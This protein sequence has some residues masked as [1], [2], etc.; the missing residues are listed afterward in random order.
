MASE[1]PTL[2]I[3]PRLRPHIAELEFD[4]ESYAY[5][6]S[7]MGA[8]NEVIADTEIALLGSTKTTNVS[9]GRIALGQYDEL[10]NRISIWPLA[11]A[12]RLKGCLPHVPQE[13]LSQSKTPLSGAHN[14]ILL[15][16][17]GHLVD[18]HRTDPLER[19][20]TNA[21]IFER[22]LDM[23]TKVA[24]GAVSGAIIGSEAAAFADVRSYV[25]SIVGAG[26]LGAAGLVLGAAKHREELKSTD[27]QRRVGEKAAHDFS[28]DLAA[29]AL[30][31][32]V[33]QI[34]LR[35]SRL[36]RPVL[37]IIS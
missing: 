32:S 10:R 29:I 9:E 37:G 18:V 1:F 17:S 36:R 34:E 12:A 19:I 5:G 8:S 16:E 20:K 7:L 2:T 22:V 31:G 24:T 27:E 3:D 6:L 15:H 33:L 28:N 14:H 21:Q 25:G 4:T 13:V 23:R 30:M 35:R 26:V 11:I